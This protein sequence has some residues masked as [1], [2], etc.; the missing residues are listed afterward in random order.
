VVLDPAAFEARRAAQRA[1]LRT[2][3]ADEG[4]PGTA[5]F[6]HVFSG[7]MELMLD[8]EAMRWG[9]SLRPGDRV[10]LQAEPPIPA[11]VKHVAP[12]RERT[13]VRLVVHGPDQA[14][15]AVG[16]RL[17]LRMPPPS[18]QVEESA[19]PADL[20]RPRTK[21]ER[22]EWLLASVYCPCK[23][24]GDTCTGHCYT[25][26]SCNPNTCGM[27]RRMRK[28]VAEKIDRGLTDRQL[29]EQ[30]RAEFGPALLRPHLLP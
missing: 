19:G 5:T 13:L 30:L 26:A 12:W 23:V 24:G 8:H 25:L 10:S 7:E 3:W 29:L 11:V 17:R 22:I 16:E 9:R 1:A 14:D 21:E 4:L 6:L 27:P 20:D 2:R 28:I 15:L 18:H